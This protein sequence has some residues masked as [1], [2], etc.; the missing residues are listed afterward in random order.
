M[1]RYCGIAVNP[2]IFPDLSIVVNA[3]LASY[4]SVA[5]D[6]GIDSDKNG[7]SYFSGIRYLSAAI[8]V[9]TGQ[10]CFSK[11]GSEYVLFLALAKVYLAQGEKSSLFGDA[12]ADL[13]TV[14]PRICRFPPTKAVPVITAWPLIRA[15]SVIT[16]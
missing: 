13:I 2:G 1:A 6:L 8:D 3:Y 11:R 9:L 14:A 12:Y 10:N 5:I 4:K 7:I 16:A 15:T